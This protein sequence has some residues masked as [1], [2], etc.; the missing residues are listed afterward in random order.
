[1]S[2]TLEQDFKNAGKLASSYFAFSDSIQKMV[3]ELGEAMELHALGTISDTAFSA[4][5]GGY[6]GS[7]NA[8]RLGFVRTYDDSEDAKRLYSIA[9][10]W[11]VSESKRGLDDK[12]L[13]VM[14]ESKVVGGT[15]YEGFFS[16]LGQGESKHQFQYG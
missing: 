9:K 8:V 5:I 15:T 1:M 11:C 14:Q 2:I 4:R 7:I 12:V 10:E 3:M 6:L 16:K 13:Y